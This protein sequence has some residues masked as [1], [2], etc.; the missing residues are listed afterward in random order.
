MTE[1]A[2]AGGFSI[3][4]ADLGISVAAGADV[5][6]RLVVTPPRE[7]PFSGSV[8]L[9][10]TDAVGFEELT[11][12]FSATGESVVWSLLTA[13]L[14]FGEV[15]VG[16]S[17]DL[18]ARFRNESTLSPVTLTGANF[19]SNVYRVVG[20]PFPLSVPA[21]GEGLLTVRFA[22]AEG[23]SHDGTAEF[24]PVDLGGPVR[25]PVR[26]SAPGL[27]SEVVTSYGPQSFSGSNTAALF[28]DVPANAISLTVEALGPVGSTFGL[29]E[30]VGPADN[31]YE[32]IALTGAYI[33]QPGAEV[34][35]TTVPNTDRTDVQLVPGGGTYRF[36]IRRLSGAASSVTVRA[37]VELRDGGIASLVD[38]NVWLAAG[39]SVSA[40]TA[41]ADTR[42]QAILT[43]LD[44]ILG[45]QSIR[46]GDIAYYDVSDPSYDSVTSSAEFSQMLQTTGAATATRLNLF[47]VQTA[48]GGGVVG[49]AATVS[50]P[51]RNGTTLSG[52]MSIYTGFSTNVIGLIAAHELGHF[53]GLYH[54]VE[55]T[56]DHD[57][58]DDTT[59]C[60][61]QGTSMDCP[62]EGGGYLMHWQA[63]GGTALTPG[64]GL[65]LRAHPLL[66]PQGGGVVPKPTPLAGPQMTL[67]DWIEVTTLTPD[68]CGNCSPL[69]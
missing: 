53:L 68:W 40:A 47:F 5:V 44:S 57:F 55:Q 21:G 1:T 63:V 56:G 15:P 22:P 6:L 67:W 29:G 45:Q 50:G 3:L 39:L 34:F 52:V 20:S 30:L 17:A 32:N 9:R 36:R 35:S 13:V 28:V 60:P 59:D 37:I 62:T 10:F 64:Q 58:V 8:S 11:R 14:D 24:G 18:V 51:K 7:G 42:L 43:Q 66:R 48:L 31:V 46:V 54:T 2:S 69:R 61:A 27:G 16:G 26:G 49:V 19:T 33:W 12:E 38:L 23:G 65:V 25:L 41:A 4:P